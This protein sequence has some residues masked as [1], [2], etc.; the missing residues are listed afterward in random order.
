MDQPGQSINFFIVSQKQKSLKFFTFHGLQPGIV[1]KKDSKK[2]LS[3]QNTK[4]SK[5]ISFFHLKTYFLKK[6]IYFYLKIEISNFLYFMDQ[7]GT[8]N[9]SDFT[10]KNYNHQKTKISKIIFFFHLKT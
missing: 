1:N 2:N 6:Y 9:K 5:K 3:S 7:P 8:I 10:K 4:I